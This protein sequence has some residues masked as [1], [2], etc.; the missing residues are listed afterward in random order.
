[1]LRR[2]CMRGVRRGCALMELRRRVVIKVKKKVRGRWISGEATAF[3][4]RAVDV[5]RSGQD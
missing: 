2:G 1:M 4:P 3:V 5:R